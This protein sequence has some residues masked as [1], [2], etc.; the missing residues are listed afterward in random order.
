MKLP[1]AFCQRTRE[2]PTM[3][4]SGN[5]RSRISSS[6]P[7]KAIPSPSLAN[8]DTGTKQNSNCQAA[9]NFSSRGWLFRPN[10]VDIDDGSG[11]DV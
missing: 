4:E 10:V 6:E 8:P 2:T 9:A 3:R 11:T 5:N 1:L 7:G